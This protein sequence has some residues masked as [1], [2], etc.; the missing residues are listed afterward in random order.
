MF[1]GETG[2]CSG[3]N[4]EKVWIVIKSHYLCRYCNEKRKRLEKKE[5]KTGLK[6]KKVKKFKKRGTLEVFQAI[7]EVR[8]HKSEISGTPLGKFD[9]FNF[10]HILSKGS[11]PKFALKPNNICLMTRDEHDQY[12]NVGNIEELAKTHDGWRKLLDRKDKLKAKYNE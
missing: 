3:C 5:R 8:E 10:A 11:H 2:T 4:R 6:P 1:N 9:I 12:D 7:W